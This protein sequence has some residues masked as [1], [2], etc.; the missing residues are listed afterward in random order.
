MVERWCW[1]GL[2]D[3]GPGTALARVVRGLSAF[4]PHCFRRFGCLNSGSTFTVQLADLKSN[5]SEKPQ[6]GMSPPPPPYL[7]ELLLSW[8]LPELCYSYACA[9]LCAKRT[10]ISILT[11][12]LELLA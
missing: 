3:R 6:G 8:V 10:W 9:F 7:Q 5:C 11:C 1:D 2:T 4:S 12:A